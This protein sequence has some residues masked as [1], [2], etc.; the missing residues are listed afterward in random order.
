MIEAFE[1]AFK[2]SHCQK[3]SPVNWWFGREPEP[4]L[5][6]EDDEPKINCQHCGKEYPHRVSLTVF[7]YPSGRLLRETEPLE[8]TE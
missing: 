2:C 5:T 7:A 1:P 3:I 4:L 6:L 8:K